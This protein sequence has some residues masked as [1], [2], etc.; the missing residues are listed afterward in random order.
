L[1]QK[2]GGLKENMDWMLRR[3]LSESHLWQKHEDGR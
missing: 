1:V 3:W 2:Q